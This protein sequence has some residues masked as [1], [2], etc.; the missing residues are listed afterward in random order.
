MDLRMRAFSKLPSLIGLVIA[1]SPV[2][3][4]REIATVCADPGE[5]KSI[6]MKV[7]RGE[8]SAGTVARDRAG[9]LNQLLYRHLF[10]EDSQGKLEGDLVEKYTSQKNGR[11][12]RMKLRNGIR[13]LSQGRFEPSRSLNSDDVLYSLERVKGGPGADL[14]AGITSWRKLGPNDLEMRLKDPDPDIL[15]KLADPRLMIVS[16][17]FEQSYLQKLYTFQAIDSIPLGNGPFHVTAYVNETLLVL[18]RAGSK[19]LRLFVTISPYPWL[20]FEKLATRECHAWIDSPEAIVSGINSA[21][22]F[23]RNWKGFSELSLGL[24]GSVDRRLLYR[25]EIS[26]IRVSRLGIFDL[27]EISGQ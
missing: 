6:Q 7:N 21:L 1:W 2:A 19:P 9:F 20:A 23:A 5:L 22:P 3:N 13:F 14:V 26:G 18:D 25:P 10:S 11:V 24:N 16:S 8:P 4:G 27:T 12:Y 17:E 15:R